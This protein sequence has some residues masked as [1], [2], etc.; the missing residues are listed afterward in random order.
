METHFPAWRCNMVAFYLTTFCYSYME[1]FSSEKQPN[2]KLCEV[3]EANVHNTLLA[4][5]L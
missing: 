1:E 3:R 4:A 2:L 5:V